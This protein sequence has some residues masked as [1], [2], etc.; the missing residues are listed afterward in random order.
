M[1]GMFK[2]LVRVSMCCWLAG[3]AQHASAQFQ[4]DFTDGDF[5]GSPTWSGDASLFTVVDDGG[6]MRLRS[7][8]SGAGTTT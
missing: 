6:N 1:K 3:L 2:L 5:T 4:D 8:S 7:N